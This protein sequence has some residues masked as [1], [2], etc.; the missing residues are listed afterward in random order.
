MTDHE[1]RSAGVPKSTPDHRLQ[2]HIA[3]IALPNPV[4]PAS[5]TFEYGDIHRDIMDPG[6]LG[7][8][9]NKT[10][11]LEERPGNPPPRLAETPCGMLNAIGIPSKGT[12]DFIAHILPGLAQYGVPLIISIAGNSVEEFCEVARR[13]EETGRADMLEVNLSCPNLSR[14]I[15]WAQDEKQLVQVLTAVRKAV[16]LPLVAKLSPTVADIGM[17]GKLAEGAGADAVSLVNT[18]KG[19]VIDPDRKKPILGNLTGGLSGPSI[20]PLAVWAVYSVYEHV[21]IPVIGMGGVNSTESALELILAGAAG[22]G[23]GMYNFI[24]PR[25]MV[26]IIEGLSEYLDRQNVASI[27]EL[28]GAA[29]R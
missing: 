22:V 29:H 11:F 8:I 6:R 15:E 2:V 28:V 23:V 21:S 20:H 26:R 12:D 5:G 1:G 13:I 24:D 3:G 16:K 25:I 10:I 17:M 18:F 4:M 14:G 19:M 9:V 7:A 27:E